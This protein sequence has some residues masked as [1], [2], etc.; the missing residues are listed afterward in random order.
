M[1][2]PTRRPEPPAEDPVEGS[3]DAPEPPRPAPGQPELNDFPGYGEPPPDVHRDS[4]PHV[5]P[6][7]RGPTDDTGR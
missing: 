1:E 7:E 4:P 2:P 6:R 5:P 3:P